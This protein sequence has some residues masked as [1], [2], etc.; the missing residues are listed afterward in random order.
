MTRFGLSVTFALL[1]AG[2]GPSVASGQE[3]PRTADVARHAVWI[4]KVVLKTRPE[5]D[6]LVLRARQDPVGG[7]LRALD[8]LKSDTTEI[9]ALG[10]ELA[11]LRR[12]LPRELLEGPDAARIADA[13]GVRELVAD[14][15][16]L[17]VPLLVEESDA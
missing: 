12:K 14:I 4:E 3:H 8:A 6:P 1:L 7:L 10:D 15:E 17:L 9:G 16:G 5:G 2:L 13:A 11:E